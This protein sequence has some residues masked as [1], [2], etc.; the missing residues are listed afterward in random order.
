MFLYDII[1]SQHS[2]I[3]FSTGILSVKAYALYS[4]ANRNCVATVGNAFFGALPIG[5]ALFMFILGGHNVKKILLLMLLFLSAILILSGCNSNSD[6]S[7]E[8]NNTNEIY[9]NQKGSWSNGVE[10]SIYNYKEPS[11]LD[12][13]LYKYTTDN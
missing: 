2:L 12:F 10:F 1:I 3:F 6:F 13:G 4:C 9:M 5:S 8:K 7:N 11:E